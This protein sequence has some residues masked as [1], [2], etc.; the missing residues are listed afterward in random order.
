MACGERAMREDRYA[1]MVCA[2]GLENGIK[3]DLLRGWAYKELNNPPEKWFISRLVST[4][5]WKYQA[6]ITKIVSDHWFG[7]EAVGKDY[8]VW[9]ECDIIEDGLSKILEAFSKRFPEGVKYED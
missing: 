2:C 3:M 6:V 8:S 4:L 9:V 1:G 5:D 7:L